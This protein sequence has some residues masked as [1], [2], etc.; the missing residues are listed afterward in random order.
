MFG[1]TWKLSDDDL[2]QG[3]SLDISSRVDINV[4]PRLPWIDSAVSNLCI[5]RQGYVVP[6]W[7]VGAGGQSLH[8]PQRRLCSVIR[9]RW[10]DSSGSCG[11]LIVLDFF[12]FH[13]LP[14]T[15]YS[16][17]DKPN[18]DR[19]A[20]RDG[21]DHGGVDGTPVVDVAGGLR[22]GW[23]E[24]TSAAVSLHKITPSRTR[25]KRDTK[26]PRMS[27]TLKAEV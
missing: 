10:P 3:I 26:R 20:N 24:V 15:P 14:D 17:T 12:R 8:A 23:V 7:A 27:A 6:I 5:P 4:S 13:F 1:K 25:K 16:N 9:R 19:T 11:L 18:E 22:D 21:H 2:V